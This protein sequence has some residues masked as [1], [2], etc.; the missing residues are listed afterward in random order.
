MRFGD[1]VF[2]YYYNIYDYILYVFMFLVIV[3]L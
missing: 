2:Y 1:Q 3:N